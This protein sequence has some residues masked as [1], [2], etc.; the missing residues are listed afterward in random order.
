MLDLSCRDGNKMQ[1]I[2]GGFY[3]ITSFGLRCL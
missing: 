1:I 3:V 2:L